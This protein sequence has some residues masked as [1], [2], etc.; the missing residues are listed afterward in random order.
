MAEVRLIS[1]LKG[2]LYYID[3]PLLDFEIK[4]R[5]LIKAVNLSEGR[6][7]PPELALYGITYGNIND[8]FRRRTMDE[9]CM[10]YQEHLKALHLEKFDFDKYIMLNNG[11]NHL[12]NY[13]VRF[14]NFGA[15]CFMD[16]CTQSGYANFEAVHGYSPYND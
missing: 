1:N 7:F 13:W 2:I 12:D 8:F 14:E 3:M 10:F 11:N 9:G 4:N 16:I 15:R 6:R 5:E